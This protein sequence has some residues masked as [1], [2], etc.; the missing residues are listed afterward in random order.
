[1]SPFIILVV[2]IIAELALSPEKKKR[3]QNAEA[4]ITATVFCLINIVVTVSV[5]LFDP[6]LLKTT[7]WI[8]ILF[9]AVL[10]LGCKLVVRA[11]N[12][13]SNL[14]VKAQYTQGIVGNL[15]KV[16]YQK[17]EVGPELVAKFYSVYI[18]VAA[19]CAAALLYIFFIIQDNYIGTLNGGLFPAQ[20]G[21]ALISFLV[22]T[23]VFVSGNSLF[24]E[25]LE[26]YNSRKSCLSA[27]ELARA[28]YENDDDYQR[29][30]VDNYV[31]ENKHIIAATKH[32][33]VDKEPESR[34]SFYDFETKKNYIYEP[35]KVNTAL[36]D[37]IK[38][39]GYEVNPLYCAAYNLIE[40]NKNVLIKSP[41]YVDFEPYFAAIIKQKISKTEKIVFI[42]NSAENQ[43]SVL[44]SIQ[45]V[46]KEN[47]G[48]EVV[49]LFRTIS[50]WHHDLKESE[51][52]SKRMRNDHFRHIEVDFEKESAGDYVIKTPDVIIAS[53][54]EV[55]NPE[56]TQMI[57]SL[58]ERLGLIVYYNFNDCIQE[59]PLY[60]KIVHSILD[61]CD[62][63][64]SLYMTDGFFDFEQSL[65]NFFSKRAIY[66]ISIPRKAPTTSYDMVWKSENSHELQTRE[67]TDASRDF[68]M[69][70]AILYYSLGFVKNDAMIVADEKDT[71]SE[72][73]LN[74]SD[75]NVLGRIDHNVGWSDIMGG[76]NVMCTVS[77]TYNNIAHTYLSI[78][79]IGTRSE[80][81]NI[82]S[83]P[84]LLRNYLAKHLK[85][86]SNEP[87]SVSTFSSG[88]IR[89]ERAMALQVVIKAFIIGY[90]TAQVRELS[91]R[92]NFT[93]GLN[94]TEILSKIACIACDHE[95]DAVVVC[96]RTKADRYFFDRDTYENVLKES[97]LLSKV[98]FHIN[99]QIVERPK[100][101]F[102]YL[103]PLQKIVV[104]GIKYTVLKV[105]G[106][107]VKLTN[108]NNRDPICAT[109]I[110]RNNSATI[111]SSGNYGK[112]YQ[113]GNDS[114]IDF[115]HLVCDLDVSPLG[116]ISFKDHYSLLSGK[117]NF[118][119]EKFENIAE[120]HYKNSNVF[121]IRIGC[122][123]INSSNKDELA[124]MMALLFNEMMPTFFPKYSEKIMISCSGWGICRDL[125]DKDVNTRYIVTPLDIDDPEPAKD[126]EICIY[127]AEDSVVE[128]GTINVFW[129]DEEFRYMLKILEDYLYFVEYIDLDERDVMFGS[130]NDDIIHQL[131]K[132]LLL[133]I[134][135][136][137]DS[138]PGNE[139]KCINSIRRSRNKFYMLD[140]AKKYNLYCD[141]CGKPIVDVPGMTNNYHYY[142]YSGRISCP[143]CYGK[144]V[145]SKKYSISDIRLIENKVRKW[146]DKKYGATIDGNFYNYLEDALFVNRSNRKEVIITDDVDI[147][148][149]ALGYASTGYE[150]DEELGF[151]VNE[152]AIGCNTM[153]KEDP[154]IYDI[155][156]TGFHI[157]RNDIRHILISEGYSK[158]VYVGCQ[159]HELTHQWQF[160]KLDTY[161]MHE[162]IPSGGF[163]E[164]GLPID[165]TSFRYEGHAVWAELEYLKKNGYGSLA[166][167]RK[168]QFLEKND[169]YGFGYRWIRRL[170]V[171]GA[172]DPYAPEGIHTFGFCIRLL[173]QQLKSNAF[174]VMELYYGGAGYERRKKEND[175]DDRSAEEE[176]FEKE[177]GT[178]DNSQTDLTDTES[179][180]DTTFAEGDSP[181]FDTSLLGETSGDGSAFIDIETDP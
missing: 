70:I 181:P 92:F 176:P 26:R 83:R 36:M 171:P 142:S 73:M 15:V 75:N 5:S 130:G 120:K 158:D 25:M 114:Y 47:F 42:V 19:F 27:R 146:L 165:L 117:E 169:A 140:L 89:S 161:K 150:F 29:I 79:G 102:P 88:I 96:D 90:D 66:Q 82:I 20:T 46:F 144:S 8:M 31:N 103:I 101:K 123:K 115:T 133:V 97:E 135:D 143:S 87:R 18:G 175:L 84:Y 174:G 127:I 136:H 95:V 22:E 16:F 148:L 132:I 159:S 134:N 118:V 100:R 179:R 12:R 121:K 53:P 168:K 3:Y 154:D 44:K 147:G 56:Y 119:Y 37:F 71:Y 107:H 166:S 106:D 50:Q 38:E 177:L 99:D 156:R 69:H 76:K 52:L 122:E 128:T 6:T 163:D 91:A 2:I 10:I 48:F 98:Y 149:R 86:F 145:C 28:R 104:N 138:D 111:K 152:E 170:M 61:S 153:M 32:N 9:Q 30:F 173:F 93:D 45:R 164:F 62:S 33:Y 1:M 11:R 167:K 63:V 162:N 68:G 64:S 172:R 125:E 124:H 49:P 180:D 57:R 85:Y 139:K 58:I 51:Q 13:K 60:A 21:T 137:P 126:N 113:Y 112:R 41:S 94:E 7:G 14:P 131:R 74:Y 17:N 4:L 54:D 59:E 116:R 160:E 178:E 65:D 108:S 39:N 78:R 109:R 129:Q 157:T 43:S 34:I 81:V 24:K 40:E 35:S 151:D 67:I 80:Y 72:V 141:F 77:D 155:E 55:C 23:G 110:I 105:D